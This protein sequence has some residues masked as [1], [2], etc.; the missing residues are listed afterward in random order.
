MIGFRR[1]LPGAEADGFRR[2][3]NVV[4]AGRPAGDA[5]LVAQLRRLRRDPEKPR[6]HDQAA[7]ARVVRCR[8]F[9][10]NGVVHGER[11]LL[12]NDAARGCLLC[13][14]PLPP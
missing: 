11:N 8:Y 7:D 4:D 14:A 3:Q 12:A 13:T 5:Q 2:G 1:S 9:I 10:R 6:E